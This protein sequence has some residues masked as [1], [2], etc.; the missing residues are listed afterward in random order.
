[1]NRRDFL[2]AFLCFSAGVAACELSEN[3]YKKVR[4]PASSASPLENEYAQEDVELSYV[5]LQ[6]AA[7]CNL[8]CKSCCSFSPLSKP[9]YIGFE[10]FARDF[11]KLKELY[12]DKEKNIDLIYS[13]GEPLLNPDI[14]RIIKLSH[15][16]FPKSNKTILTNGILLNDMSNDFWK[17]VKDS[18]VEIQ[19][20]E[21]PINIDRSIYEKKIKNYGI[22]YS[23]NVLK[24][25][26]LFDLKTQKII[27]KDI[28]LKNAR[29][30]GKPIMDLTGKQDYIEKRYNCIHK[31]EVFSYIRGNLY[32]CY[33]HALINSFIDYFKLDVHLTNKDF[34]KIE[35]I[36][37]VQEINEFLS[38]PKPLCRYCK[39]CHNLDFGGKPIEWEFSKR[40]ITEW[41]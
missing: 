24:S 21:Y 19:V 5:Y 39:Q 29:N 6:M 17:V 15:K 36:K 41:T 3:E 18:D 40:E 26:Q 10:E 20:A 13:G 4:I 32:Y 30:W 1:M 37:S 23:K 28:S 2:I 16:L 22:K 9:E 12:S 34:L 25:C 33:L 14:T 31:N 38:S 35:D 11:N 27:Q 7:N 8:N